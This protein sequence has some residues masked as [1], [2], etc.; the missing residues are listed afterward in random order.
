MEARTL[1]AALLGCGTLDADFLL[2]LIE[3]QDLCIYDLL[4]D[5]ADWRRTPQIKANDLIYA[6]LDRVAHDFLDHVVK[7]RISHFANSEYTLFINCLD[8]HI[9]FEDE[10]LNRWFEA[11]RW[12]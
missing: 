6:A 1:I 4:D 8:S 9:W 5:V 11:W 10:N 7:G 12:S 3:G 2:R